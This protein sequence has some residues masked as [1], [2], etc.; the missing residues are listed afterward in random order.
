[1]TNNVL[2]FTFLGRALL[3]SGIVMTLSGI[4][5]SVS[6]TIIT[7]FSVGQ[8]KGSFLNSIFVFI[9]Y[10]Y[11]IILYNLVFKFF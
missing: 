10:I 7:V 1:M 2:W 6:S 5:F 11:V 8:C 4:F 9:C 3:S